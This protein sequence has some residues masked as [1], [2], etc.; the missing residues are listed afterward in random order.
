[1]YRYKEKINKILLKI[2][3]QFLLAMRNASHI[4]NSVQNYHYGVDG[5]MTPK[6][7]TMQFHAPPTRREG[8][9][10]TVLT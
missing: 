3:F 10:N 8:E 5:P 6:H 7:T 2:H 1:M 4:K 9:V